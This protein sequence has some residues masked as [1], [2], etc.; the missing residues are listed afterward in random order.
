MLVCFRSS[1]GGL[2]AAGAIVLCTCT[3]LADPLPRSRS[4]VRVDT[5]TGHLV[6]SVVVRSRVAAPKIVS[7]PTVPLVQPVIE[8][9]PH[10]VFAPDA[11][12]N[13]IV[14]A[15]ARMYDVDPLLVHSVIQ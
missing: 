14:D 10:L 6:R 2:L 5:H 1:R 4:K 3:A 13:E 12:V 9:E 11:K 7:P 8:P 15:T